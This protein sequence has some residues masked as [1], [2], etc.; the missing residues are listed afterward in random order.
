MS[1]SIEKKIGQM[2]IMGFDSLEVNDH[3][4]YLIEQYNLGN[5]ILF[6]RN[7]ENDNQVKTLC[8]DLN[9]LVLKHSGIKPFISVD[10][11]GGSV[12]RLKKIIGEYPSHLSLGL[13]N[14]E[15]ITKEV[16]NYIGN[17]LKGL[18][19][20]M[21][22][23]PLADINSNIE[24]P[25]IGIR[26]F[27][28]N[29]E[30]VTKMVNAMWKGYDEAN[31]LPVIKHFPGH[32][33]TNV[34][35]HYGLPTVNT[36]IEQLKNNE[37]VPFK[38]CI[39]DGVNGIMVSHVIIN[40]IDKKY[41]SS[42]S[43]KVM[44]ELL[45]DEMGY[46]GLI[47]TDCFEMGAIKDNFEIE[48]SVVKSILAGADIIDVSH[49]KELQERA[50][51]AVVDAVKNGEIK[52]E[53]I[54]RSYDRIMKAKKKINEEKMIVKKQLDME[55]LYLELIT[56]SDGKIKYNKEKSVVLGVLPY[57]G[58]PA[59]DEITDNLEVVK[60]ISDKLKIN[61]INFKY[62]I[63]KEEINELIKEVKK[64]DEIFLCTADMD[65]HK[66]QYEI[67]EMLQNKKVIL[68]NM[69]MIPHNLKY[70]PMAYV[71]VGGYTD[72]S[73]KVLGDYILNKVEEN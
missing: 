19:V 33:D 64:Y 57:S 59:E 69:R 3:I 16:A 5:F 34:D 37:L 72:L 12:T 13:K 71:N 31:I 35:S 41:P 53:I 32:G 68:I 65:I 48:K 39:E 49:T 21:N 66:N 15:N 60:I 73:V 38:K 58:T 25:V 7:I 46:E 2:F 23:A 9:D 20:N 56:G 14:D 47:V 50:L 67:Y 6:T 61:G 45:R 28:D 63:T 4:K 24:N 51:K 18:G 22:L 10:E 70:K 26:A 62:D 27:G 43:K 42:L 30:V 11:E 17:K 40:S 54:N 1:T 44:T 55:K 52:E 8:K 36:T 29:K